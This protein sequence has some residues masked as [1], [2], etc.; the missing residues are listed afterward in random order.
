MELAKLQYRTQGVLK[1][2]AP[3]LF[4]PFFR[5]LTSHAP[6]FWSPVQQAQ[7]AAVPSSTPRIARIP[8]SGQRGQAGLAGPDVQA[9]LRV[10]ARGGLQVTVAQA[11]NLR[12]TDVIG[13]SDPFAELSTD[14]KYTATTKC[15]KNTLSPKWEE[16]FWMLV[17]VRRKAV[18]SFR[19]APGEGCWRRRVGQ[20]VLLWRSRRAELRRAW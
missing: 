2:C 20:A 14:G 9:F 13:S 18:S 4:L 10:R 11:S 3:L 16:T 12:K 7:Q 6:R 8:R 17:Q 5:P 1:V 19:E 15:I